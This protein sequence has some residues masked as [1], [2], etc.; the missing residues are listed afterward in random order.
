MRVYALGDLVPKI[1][2]ETYI[3]DDVMIIGD[4][5]IAKGVNIWPGVVLRGDFAEIV[6]GENCNI[7]ENSTFHNAPDIPVI[8]EE[9]ITIGHN[10]VIHGCYI[11]KNCIIG[12][13]STVLNNS[14]IPKNCIV[15]ANALVTPK[16]KLEEGTLIIGA[17][18]KSVRKLT[19]AEFEKIKWNCDEYLKMAER[20]KKELKR[21]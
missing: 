16:S 1:N 21:I 15:G 4:V 11:E 17:P 12:M 18:A 8:L 6:I 19:E 7:Q 20:F 9:N 2:E 14:R 13:N 3:F 5:E 10:V